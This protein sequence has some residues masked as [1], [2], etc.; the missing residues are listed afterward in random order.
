MLGVGLVVSNSRALALDV[1]ANAS[2]LRIFSSRIR[3]NAIGTAAALCEG[4]IAIVPVIIIVI[5][6]CRCIV[7]LSLMFVLT[8]DE[9]V[10]IILLVVRKVFV[11]LLHVLRGI[12]IYMITFMTK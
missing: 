6:V 7:K 11:L 3:F 12:T 1:V 2:S 4:S 9:G 8:T 10:E 5:V